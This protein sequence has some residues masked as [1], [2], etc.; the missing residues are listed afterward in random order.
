[1]YLCLK[2]V[3]M[4]DTLI[5]EWR[6]GSNFLFFFLRGLCSFKVNT[7]LDVFGK[8]N[9]HP[10]PHFLGFLQLPP[11]YL[12][13]AHMGARYRVR[14]NNKTDKYSQFGFMFQKTRVCSSSF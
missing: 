10:F 3:A 11:V 12:P 13:A 8:V 5:A 14:L 4:V 2:S 1:M 9:T 6:K 7:H